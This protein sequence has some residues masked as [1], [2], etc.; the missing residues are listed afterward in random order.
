MAETNQTQASHLVRSMSWM[1]AARLKIVPPQ[2]TAGA[3]DR[4]PAKYFEDVLDRCSP[5]QNTVLKRLEVLSFSFNPEW[6]QTLPGEPLQVTGLIV[7]ENQ[8]RI[9]TVEEWL[10]HDDLE[11]MWSAITGRRDKDPRVGKFLAESALHDDFLAARASGDTGAPNLRVDLIGPSAPSKKLGR[12]A[13]RPHPNGGFSTDGVIWA[14][15]AAAPT[16]VLSVAAPLPT[17]ATAPPDAAACGTMPPT[18]EAAG[19]APPAT[20]LATPPHAAAAG[21]GGQS[22]PANTP[23]GGAVAESGGAVAGF[24]STPS[25]AAPALGRG[26]ATPS[27]PAGPTNASSPTSPPTSSDSPS[28]TR[29]SSPGTDSALASAPATRPLAICRCSASRPQDAAQRIRDL[30]RA[31]AESQKENKGLLRKL[32]WE[33]GRARPPKNLGRPPK[34]PQPDGFDDGADDGCCLLAPAFATPTVAPQDAAVPPTIT[35]AAPPDG[36]NGKI[37]LTAAAGCAP[38]A[39]VSAAPPQAVTSTP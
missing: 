17:T 22:E 13:K 3:T 33:S 23:P 21:G 38:S 26:A 12:P 5:Y 25:R 37:Q 35:A 18:A 32:E 29:L 24:P 6:S 10:V 14:P 1:F 7:N 19:A 8:I 28:S 34:H 27:T 39:C 15:A 4:I 36:A 11:I 31:L 20:A 2:Y 9:N 30:E 16:V